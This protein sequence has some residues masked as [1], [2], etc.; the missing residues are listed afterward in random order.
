[1]VKT[2]QGLNL[3]SD[4]S[5]VMISLEGNNI[6]DVSTI[7]DKI[8][9]FHPIFIKEYSLSTPLLTIRSKLPFIW[10]ESA[11]TLNDLSQEK[12]TLKEAEDYIIDS[13]IKN[14]IKS[15]S[16]IPILE[17]AHKAKLETT[18]AILETP[19][20]KGLSEGYSTVYNRYF[21]IGC[22]KGSQITGSIASSKDAYIAQKIQKDKWS[23]N[24]LIERLNLPLPKWQVISNEKKL[25]DIWDDFEKPVVIKPTG[26]TGGK[27]VTVGIDSIEK[28]KKAFNF[29]IKEIGER[30]RGE[31]QKKIM[32]QE[33]VKGED[34]RLLVINGK[35]EIVTKRIPAFITGD[36]KKTIKELIE[37]ENQDPRRNVFNPAH[38][39]K[40]IVVDDPLTEYLEE[41]GL[42]LTSIPQKGENIKVRK[43]ASMS[44][45][46]ITEDFTD[47]VSKEIK[48]IVESIAQSVHAFTLGVDVM[49]LDI[50]KPLTKDNGAILE[51]NTMPESYLNFF[52]ILGK[53][54][55]YVAEIY[56]TELLKEN[57]CK[58]FVVIGQ[59]KDDIP[60]LLRKRWTIKKEHTVGEIIEDRYYINGIQINEDLERWEAVEAIKCNASLDVIILHSRDWSDAKENG[61]GFDHIHCLYITK[62]QSLVKENMKIVNKYKRMK[63]IDK[64]RII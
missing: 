5:T 20:N 44:Q 57:N 3:E 23:T 9:S 62:E 4:F 12:I 51:I 25:E 31:W 14:R 39:L 29:A 6:G 1:M 21:V 52:P 17:S 42:T 64:I 32:I 45:G 28:G 58:K 55:G 10:R 2:I 19:I 43:V 30:N 26:L 24:V 50:S 41:Q 15:M 27:G 59:P 47:M 40:P 11:K 16:T 37:T 8:A 49:C 61:F 34:Y 36:G 56:L 35:L 46:G 33:Q 38:I 18:T 22:G 48:I 13:L 63:L 54:R 60:T 7:L 53:Q